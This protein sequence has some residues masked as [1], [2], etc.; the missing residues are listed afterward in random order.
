MLPNRGISISDV[1]GNEM[2]IQVT[3]TN[4]AQDDDNVY[5]LYSS[6]LGVTWE[7]LEHHT[8]NQGQSPSLTAGFGSEQGVY[9]GGAWFQMF[10]FDDGIFSKNC[11]KHDDVRDIQI[12]KNETSGN[13]LVVGDDGGVSFSTDG[14]YTWESLNGDHLPITQFYSIGLN[15]QD[16]TSIIGGAQDNGT[17]LGQHPNWEI[18]ETGDGGHS[19][20]SPVH[21]NRYFYQSN[22]HTRV[23][24]GTTTL[25]SFSSG[26]FIPSIQWFLGRPS[27]FDPTNGEYL[28]EGYKRKGTH[29][30]ASIVRH[31]LLGVDPPYVYDFP[32][33]TREIGVIK[34]SEE[35][36]NFIYAATGENK[37]GGSVSSPKFEM[38]FMSP[39]H[40]D[41]YIDLTQL[42]TSFI[43][44]DSEPTESTGKKLHQVLSYR[45]VNAIEIDPAFHE[46]LWIGLSGVYTEGG[47]AVEGKFRIL[48]SSNG[49]LNWEDYSN[50]LP[51][52]PVNDIIYQKYSNDLLFA[53]TDAGVFYRDKD[54]D[55]W[56]CFQ[57]GMPATFT[58][59]LEINYCSN[60][61]FAGTYGRGI[62]KTKIPNTDG[63]RNTYCIKQ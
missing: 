15:I 3:A 28:F 23:K 53:A 47:V 11:T 12:V 25:L 31:D 63:G 4:T 44:S 24:D 19:D 46:R 10:N 16:N 29:Q 37:S 49:G 17:F 52:F 58:T 38:L 6:D 54:M 41:S 35:N 36:N 51:P 50:G 18:I 1:V 48:T 32:S 56:E 13:Y 9:F 62:W 2:Y 43:L 21:A 5:L 39:N 8:G 20:F 55:A 57:N 42:S 27:E 59:D 40:G 60:E 14:G 7:V 30:V 45:N 22:S 26:S 34:I 33:T 61:L